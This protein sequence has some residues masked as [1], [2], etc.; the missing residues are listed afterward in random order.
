LKVSEKFNF[1]PNLIKCITILY[2]DLTLCIIVNNF[3]SQPVKISR[4][5]KQGC[6]L[7]PLLYVL[8][9]EPFVRKVCKDKD[10]EGLKLPRSPE[11]CKISGFADDSTDI[12]TTDKSIKKFLYLINLF[13]KASGSKL[14][15]NKTKGLWL[16][17]WKDRKDNYNIG[18]DFVECITI[19]GFQ[20]GNNATQDDIWHPIYVKFEKVLNLWKSRHLSLL[21]KS[22][23]VNV[24]AASNIWYIGSVLHMS[25]Q[26]TCKFQRLIFYFA[27]NSA[28]ARKT[29]YLIKHSGGLN[30]VNI[31]YK[32]YALRL[33][34][35]QEINLNRNTK[36]VNFSIYWIGYQ[37]RDLNCSFASLSIPHSDLVSPFY[38]KCLKVLHIFKDKCN[39]SIIRKL[40]TIYYLIVMNM[41][42]K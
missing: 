32:L 37:L 29:M 41:L 40:Y 11:Q 9:L 26:Y 38:N 6:S 19:I 35:I 39:D 17:A 4:S 24:L 33:K 25:K 3:I 36:F 13:G 20:I 30:M 10:I 18:I 34:H 5:V 1:G 12:L 8:C 15:K 23:V 21:E 16:G 42:L 28:L 31:E 22:I 27:W 14:N 7:S 2:Q